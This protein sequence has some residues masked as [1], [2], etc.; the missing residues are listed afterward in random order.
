MDGRR[1][2]AFNIAF[3]YVGTVIGAGF[4]SGR[5][6][7]QFF[8][9]FGNKSYLS[10][11][12]VTVLFMLFGLMTVK[13]S[14]TL[15]TADIGKIVMPF[16]N[17]YLE[18]FFGYVTAA[19]LYIAYIIM[20]AAGGAL[21]QEQFG[22]H[23]AFGGAILMV[24]V[25][26][27]ILGGFERISR[28]FRYI[29]P[30]L[31]VIVFLFCINIILRDLPDSGIRA[32]MKPSP[33][34]PNWYTSAMIYISY[35]MLGGIPIIANS[36][37]R[38]GTYRTAL[39]GAALGGLIL[40]LAALIMNLAMMTD[41]GLSSVSVLPILV[42]SGKLSVLFRWVYAIL[43]LIAVYSSATSNFYGF[44]TKIREGRHK[45][46]LIILACIAGFLLSLFGFAQMIA[47]VFPLEGYFGIA[48]LTAMTIHFVRIKFGRKSE[49]EETHNDGN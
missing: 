30:V 27:T 17:K 7:W 38:A 44:T 48:L 19:I 26:A 14:K 6:I 18:N 31:L 32:Q 20:A 39:F 3:L 28:N 25:I 5:E 49:N 22:L 47:F 10:V 11:L 29:I 9:V 2:S 15:G 16:D 24:M 8:G 46:T 13:I 23:R 41:T 42:L 35:N 34:A 36:T 40:G 1:L 45:K 33:M 4:A 12:S 21:F 37:Q 43:L